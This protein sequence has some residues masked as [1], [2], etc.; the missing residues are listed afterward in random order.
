[1][2][3]SG[4]QPLASSPGTPP[5]VVGREGHF[6]DAAWARGVDEDQDQSN[7]EGH[8]LELTWKWILTPLEDPSSSTRTGGFTLPC[9]SM[10]RSQE[11]LRSHQSRSLGGTATPT[12]RA[13]Q[14]SAGGVS[15]V[16]FGVKRPPMVRGWCLE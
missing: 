16:V 9:H 4:G 3:L 5:Q 14:T 1:M 10:P 6:A 8:S 13:G 15:D 7:M 12:N 2:A 11:G